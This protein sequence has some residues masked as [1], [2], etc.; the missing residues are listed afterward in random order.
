M[1]FSRDRGIVAL[2]LLMALLSLISA[3]SSFGFNEYLVLYY[4]LLVIPLVI[5]VSTQSLVVTKMGNFTA[6][7][8]GGYRDLR[9]SSCS[10]G[11]NRHIGSV[12]CV[13]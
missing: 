2:M 4:S 11:D 9:A 3:V 7:E 5:L 13:V 10:P 6:K 12:S 1:E 8:K